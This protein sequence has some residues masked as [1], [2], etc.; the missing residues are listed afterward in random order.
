MKRICFFLILFLTSQL[1]SQVVNNLVVFSNEGLKFTL[2]MNG[3]RYNMT[4]ETRVRVTNLTLKKYQVKI[5]FEDTH[6]KEHSTT[7]TFYST[8]WECEFAL[9]PKGRKKH[10]MDFFTQTRIPGWETPNENSG[11]DNTNSGNNNT[12]APIN[13]SNNTANNQPISIPQATEPSTLITGPGVSPKNQNG[14]H[15]DPNSGNIIIG[16]EQFNI[17]KN[18]ILKEVSDI[19][20]QKRAQELFKNSLLLCSQ[21][22]ETMKTM[23]TEQAKLD[24][25]K[26]SYQNTKDKENYPQLADLLTVPSLKE[27]LKKFIESQK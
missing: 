18:D 3:E 12:A 2:I 26:K 4:P 25:A 24:F 16:N 20:K 13:N 15:I 27:D 22:K 8:G 1:F 9:N 17:F 7:L 23:N 11:N 21:V 6:Y 5:I 19:A 14:V 10:T